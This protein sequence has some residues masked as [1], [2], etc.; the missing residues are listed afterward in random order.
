MTSEY[1][2][3]Q[4]SGSNVEASKDEI[5]LKDIVLK[6]RSVIRYILSKWL[7]IAFIGFIGSLLGILYSYNNKP[8]YAAITT[9]VLEESGGA[10]NLGQYA[11]L[12]SMVGVDISGA[13]GGG[14]IFQGDNLMEFYKSRAVI[15]ST[16]LSAYPESKNQLLIDRYIEFNKLRDKWKDNKPLYSIQFKQQPGQQ[17][18]RLQDSVINTIV[19]DINKSYLSVS[20]PDKK[21]SI[22]EVKVTSPDERFSKC[23]DEQIV[24]NVN[25]F[26]VAT[27]TKKSLQNLSILQ[28]QTD[29]I[30]GALNGALSSV[31]SSLDANPNPN[32]SRQILRVPSQKRQ[33]DAEANKAI[34]TQLVQNLE[35]SKVALRKET[36]L[37]QVID[38]PVY[39]LERIKFGK[40]KGVIIGAV[41]GGFLA[42]IYLVIIKLYNSI[43][44]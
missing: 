44:R 29:S 13:S 30:R 7:K 4:S 36:P 42:I 33:V 34:L 14:G 9:F 41:L 40:I 2:V 17:F 15:E 12:A 22:I 19:S 10:N 18:S 32:I 11:G 43:L 27:K 16:L 25:T 5:S 24:K 35:I 26:Y 20:K 39:P 6:I 28:H 1:I 8:V 38:E 23:F 37:I 31:A 3:N 21:L